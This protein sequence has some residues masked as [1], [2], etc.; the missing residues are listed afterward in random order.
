MFPPVI[1]VGDRGDTSFREEKATSSCLS[2]P[3][4]SNEGGAVELWGAT[5]ALKDGERR[6]SFSTSL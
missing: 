3:V 1:D 4:P 5:H 6:A 2:D